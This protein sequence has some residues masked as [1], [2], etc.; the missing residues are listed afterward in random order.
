MTEPFSHFRRSYRLG[1]FRQIL[2]LTFP[3]DG[4]LY[5]NGFVSTITGVD[6]G[7]VVL[8]GAT[9]SCVMNSIEV[10]FMQAKQI[11]IEPII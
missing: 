7:V 3:C 10:A 9:K 8:S 6:G 1:K 11:R 4:D 2:N 5:T